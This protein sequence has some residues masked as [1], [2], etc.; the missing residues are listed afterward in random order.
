ML[1]GSNPADTQYHLLSL[2]A[3]STSRA[4]SNTPSVPFYSA[5]RFLAFVSQYKVVPWL[6]SVIPSTRQLPHDTH[7]KSIQNRKELI[8]IPN[9]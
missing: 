5:Y 7:E 1:F 9:A 4:L 8:E 6:F 2:F 3:V